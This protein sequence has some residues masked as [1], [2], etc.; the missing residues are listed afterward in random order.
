MWRKL[1]N[2]MNNLMT[3]LDSLTQ[4]YERQRLLMSENRRSE[5]EMEL[6]KLDENIQR[7]NVQSVDEVKQLKNTI[8]SLRAHI[9]RNASQHIEKLQKAAVNG[10]DERKHLEETISTLRDKLEGNNGADI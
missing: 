1:E 9:E 4:D 2:E 10:R 3:H 5:K 6:R 7:S 8:K